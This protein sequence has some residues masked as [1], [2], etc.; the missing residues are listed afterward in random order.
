MAGV[1]EGTLAQLAAWG[2]VPVPSRRRTKHPAVQWTEFQERKPTTDEIAAWEA[3][4]AN[5]NCGVVTGAISGLVVLDADSDDARAWCEEQGIPDTPC[6]QTRRG[7]HWYFRHPGTRVPTKA[8]IHDT[9][10]IDIRGDGGF[11]VA[12]PSRHYDTEAERESGHIYAWV[13]SPDDVPLA[14]MPPWVLTMLTSAQEDEAP[15]PTERRNG[16]PPPPTNGTAHTSSRRGEAIAAAAMDDEESKVRNATKGERNTLLFQAAANLGEVVASGWIQESEVWERLSEAARAAKLRTHEIRTT[17]KSGLEKGKQQPRQLPPDRTDFAPRTFNPP[18]PDEP[19]G[20]YSDDMTHDTPPMMVPAVHTAHDGPPHAYFDVDTRRDE[21]MHAPQ[22]RSRYIYTPT[23]DN[24]PPDLPP[25]VSLNDARI[26][27]V[28]N[29]TVV[30]AL[31]GVGKSAVCEAIAAAAINPHA[32]TF[33]IT[34]PANARV[35]YVDGE[36]SAR[37]HWVAMDR[38]RRRANIPAG[39]WVPEHVR[40]RLYAMEPKIKTRQ[41]ELECDIEEHHPD[42]VVLDGLGD[43]IRD[44]NDA[45]EVSEFIYALDAGAKRGNYGIIATVH[46]N[47][48]SDKARGH[49]GSEAM[50][51]AEAVL[52]LKKNPDGSRTLHSNFQHGKVRN[53]RD[54]LQSSFT[55]DD[56]RRMFLSCANPDPTAQKQAA[57]YER[58]AATYASTPIGF[59]EL[60]RAVAEGE[61]FTERNG[62]RWVDAMRERGFIVMTAAGLYVDASNADESTPF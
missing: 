28:G 42:I 4:Y 24:E 27:C 44:P 35:L 50:R 9:L 7:V 12:P 53:D 61:G 32:D 31:P 46:P 37:D 52:L 41:H 20:W 16:T 22:E 62:K 19:P 3:A 13:R 26:L 48:G 23:P 55:W 36:R 59:N 49:M 21:R 38:T 47:P 39:G 57:R 60:A 58:A 45:G 33:G 30:T 51:R 56:E 11:V 29:I 18:P 15:P 40:Y 25:V 54:N 43:F 17:I 2:F 8:R 5:Q 14:D 6:V 10:G 1:S 34:T